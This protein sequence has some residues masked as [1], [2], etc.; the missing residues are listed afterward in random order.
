[1]RVITKGLKGDER[2]IV[3]G[4]LRA[5]PG[6]KVTPVTEQASAEGAVQPAAPKEASQ[7]KMSAPPPE[8]GAPAQK[9]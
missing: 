4:L 5:I 3:D 8:P 2:V 7:T 6:R 1:M 9:Q